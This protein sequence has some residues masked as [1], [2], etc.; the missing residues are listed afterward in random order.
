MV[1]Y[2]LVYALAAAPALAAVHEQ[3]DSVPRGWKEVSTPGL[4]KVASSEKT[5]FTIA[6]QR[7]N[8]ANL[9]SRLLDVSTPGS[10]QYGKWLDDDAFAVAFSPAKDAASTVATWL[11]GNGISD[12]KVDGAFV[13]FAADVGTV[14]RLLGAD[15]KHYANEQGVTKLRTLAYSIPDDVQSYVALVEPGTYF[16]KATYSPPKP[17]ALSRSTK[18][19]IDPSCSQAVTPACLKQLYNIGDYTPDAKSGSTIGFA[20]YLN[21]SSAT[22]DL[23]KY[24]DTYNLPEQSFTGVS[25]NNGTQNRDPATANDGEANLDVQV[26]SSV[27]SP[28]PLTEFSTGGLP[29]FLP[30]IDAP[31][32]QDNQNEPYLNFYRYILSQPRSKL[33]LIISTSYGDEESSV[34]YYYASL[35]CDMIGLVG[36]RGITVLESSGDLGVGAGCKSPTNRTQ[37]NAIFP[38][39]C[40]YL[41]TVGGTVALQPEKA[42]VGSSGGFSEYFRRPWYQNSAVGTY[43][44]SHISP[45]TQKYY[46]A[47]TDFQGRGFP[48]VSAHS[49]SPY[50]ATFYNGKLEGNGG[51]SASVPLFSGI[52]ALLNDARL[53]AGK[54][55]LGWLNPLLYSREGQKALTDI[56]LGNSVGCNGKNTQ[57]GGNEPPGSGIVPYAAWNATPGWDPVTGLGTPNFGKLKSLVLSY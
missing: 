24:E 46:S 16:G 49:A 35:V 15:Y 23:R 32:A 50:F 51:T 22:A 11:K 3:L 8:L 29:P 17:Q 6:L 9:E 54:S 56:T 37:F 13:D 48:D 12:Y 34:P 38:A 1:S 30:N 21:Q 36:L 18:R 26:I 5:T 44:K 28:L 52:V 41:T 45:A 10:A 53:R 39:T 42:W 4:S 40:P 55:S 43:L 7:Q 14:N 25:I 31:T 47:Y 27:S 2:K 57:S 20:S 33:P 19:A